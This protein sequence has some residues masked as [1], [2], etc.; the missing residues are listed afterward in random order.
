MK[1]TKHLQIL[2]L[3][4]CM[5]L[6]LVGCA[7]PGDADVS[8]T[9][10]LTTDPTPE[11]TAG[12]TITDLMGRQVTLPESV[13]KVVTL[14]A[15]NTEILFALGAEDMLVGRDAYSNYP[16]AAASI[17]AMGDY[18]APDVEAIVAA[19]A[20]VVFASTGLQK[21]TIEKLEGLDVAVVC[22]EAETFAQIYDSIELVAKVIGKEEA[23]K[24]TVDALKAR[25][26][27]VQDK[28]PAAPSRSVY[29]VM[30]YGEYGNWTGGMGS[31]INDMIVMA[32]GTCVTHDISYAWA[33]FSLETLVERDPD[34]ILLSS[35]YTTD[36]LK[37]A[38]GYKDLTAV[39]EGRVYTIS[40]D[41]VERPGPRAFDA[42]EEISQIIQDNTKG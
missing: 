41:M 37:A 7:T 39:K 2:L 29:Y 4:L 40:Y 8:P 36:D 13:E 32:G 18:T 42:L 12:G 14:T 28:A 21:E 5:A 35:L 10:T 17:P 23:G 38:A 25:A 11:A 9:P 6:A 24:E 15:S 19:G 33:D 1:K 34:I 31:F 30:S 20:D 22:S 3:I 26:Q 16:E 27:A